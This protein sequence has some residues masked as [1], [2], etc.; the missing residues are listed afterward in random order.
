MI[1]AVL[2]VG[3][4]V[5][6]G[7]AWEPAIWER[8]MRAVQ[9]FVLIIGLL[10]SSQM[11]FAIPISLVEVIIIA[12]RTATLFG[13]HDKQEED[14]AIES[15]WRLYRA[16]HPGTVLGQVAIG[17]DYPVSNL[18]ALSTTLLT[19][20]FM[21]SQ[22]GLPDIGPA[23]TFVV[24][25]ANLNPLTPNVYTPLGISSDAAA[26]FALPYTVAGFEPLIRAHP[27]DAI[28][29]PVFIGGEGGENVAVGFGVVI[30]GV[31]EPST[32][33]FV[34][35]AILAL[36]SFARARRTSPRAGTFHLKSGLTR[37]DN[38]R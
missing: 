18:P 16:E 4:P 19:F 29:Q 1:T 22:T 31:P 10:S 32:I 13:I 9:V 24:Y 25:E 14:E 27:F 12:E 6:R 35:S 33:L 38:A 23:V 7:T 15:A 34:S 37:F 30:N 28:G 8:A 21:D 26:Q 17:S 2:Y 5:I 20:F 3:Q 36:G 11:L